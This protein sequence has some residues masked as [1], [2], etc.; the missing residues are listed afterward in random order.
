M[1]F[2]TCVHDPVGVGPVDKHGGI[3]DVVVVVDHLG[4]AFFQTCSVKNV[5]CAYGGLL[6]VFYYF[7]D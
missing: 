5:E 1:L 6:V 7:V 2:P 4:C 3:G